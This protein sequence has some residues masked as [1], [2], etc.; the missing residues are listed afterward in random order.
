MSALLQSQTSKLSAKKAEPK[1]VAKSAALPKT[2]KNQTQSKS[3]AYL[4]AEPADIAKE[5]SNAIAQKNSASIL[6]TVK[7]A[8]RAQLESLS[9]DTAKMHSLLSLKIDQNIKD[10]LDELYEYVTDDA[11]MQSFVEK[12]YGITLGSKTIRG[13]LFKLLVLS[14]DEETDWT[15]NGAKHLYYSLGLLPKS[16]VDKVTSITTTN[17]T[18]GGGGVAL[19]WTGAYNI[20]YTD[21]NTD[22]IAGRGYCESDKDYKYSLN[23]LNC[24]MVHELGHIVDIGKR[25][26]G[27][28]DFRAISDWKSE[29][30]SPSKIAAR[31]EEN[32]ILPFPSDL[33]NEE[34]QIAREG[35]K[36]LVK[37]RVTG[38][39]N[40]K[41]VREN[42]LKQV[43][44]A[45]KNLGKRNGEKTS[46][47]REKALDFFKGNTDSND[48]RDAENLTDALI[49]STVYKHIAR[50][51]TYTS[52]TPQGTTS[53]YMPWYKGS[54]DDMKRQMHE[55]YENRGWYSFA[56][57]AWSQKISM[58][59]FRDPGEEFAEL[60]ATYHVANPKGSKT[61][62]AHKKW[63][64]SMGLHKD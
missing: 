49:N 21:S 2:A 34:K 14:G 28:K 41:P 23:S 54:R 27:R 53:T 24:T 19:D 39:A 52:V 40:G 57:E 7:K 30:N 4:A 29:G 8:T 18:N 50:S 1:S 6:S 44:T 35:A 56:N 33:T 13:K 42:I 47:F 3:T 55:G 5:F 51:F 62:D 59:Q 12:R 31:I 16:H 61:S 9:A 38:D 36:L 37:H 25:Y 63:F 11:V 26:S 32:A 15:L 10:T 48:Y 60:Y 45:Y 22:K 46:S 17:T 58:Y 64:E 43:Q 20:K